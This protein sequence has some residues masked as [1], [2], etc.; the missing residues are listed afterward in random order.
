MGLFYSKVD[1]QTGGFQTENVPQTLPQVLF[2]ESARK[3]SLLDEKYL[4]PRV[5]KTRP[6]TESLDLLALPT[7][8]QTP[9][10]EKWTDPVIGPA[11]C[12]LP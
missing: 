8:A 10:E 11:E 1:E 2:N 3:L 5:D 12:K 6:V 9:P 4:I 7:S